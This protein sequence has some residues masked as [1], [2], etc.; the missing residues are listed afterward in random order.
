LVQAFKSWWEG[1]TDS[2]MISYTSFNF[3]KMKWKWIKVSSN[4]ICVFVENAY[5]EDSIYGFMISSVVGWDTV[6]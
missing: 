3:L 5:V 1:Y 2:K 6:L 4:K